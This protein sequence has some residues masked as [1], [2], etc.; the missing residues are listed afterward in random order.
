[1]RPSVDVA[2][3]TANGVR[4]TVGVHADHRNTLVG[5]LGMP[6]WHVTTA[7]SALAGFPDTV[8]GGSPFIFSADAFQTDG[9][10]L[11]QTEIDFGET[12]G[13][14]PTSPIDFAWTNYGTGNLN[15]T[16]VSE[17]I[18][19]TRTIDKTLQFG[20]YIGQHNNG[21]HSALYDDVDT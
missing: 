4:V 17:I 7:A 5:V 12:N 11:Y 13:D 20:E 18:Q 15:T 9:T 6:T 16:E 10:P 3:D 8:H 19:G 2:I 21:N 14:V 1:M